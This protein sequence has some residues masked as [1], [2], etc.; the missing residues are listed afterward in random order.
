LGGKKVIVFIIKGSIL[1]AGNT[2]EGPLVG[3]RVKNEQKIELDV[4]AVVAII[5]DD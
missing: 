2:Y 4:D 5:R 1:V 3:W